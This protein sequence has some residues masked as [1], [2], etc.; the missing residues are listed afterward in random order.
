MKAMILRRQGP[1]EDRPLEHAD[2][3][4]SEP[5][6]GELV[7][8]VSACAVCHTDL[9]VVEG[10]LPPIVLPIVPGHQIVGVVEQAG[11]G[12]TQVKTG[13]RVGIPWLRRTCGACRYCLD[14]LENLCEGAEF[15]G[16]HAHGGYAEY[17]VAPAEFVYPL[18]ASFPDE[19][20]A[21]LLCAGVI[22]YRALRLCEV[23]P[24]G[25]L[26]LY[27]FG[28]SAH[29]VLQ[30]ARF[31]GCQVY[32]FTRSEEHRQHAR[33]LGAAW[34]GGANEQAVPE[35]DAGIIFAPAGWLVPLALGALRPAGTLALAGIHMSPIPELDYRLLYR[36]RTLRSV[37]NLTRQ[38]VR[39]FLDVA[40][41]IRI[42]TEVTAYRLEQAN[43]ALEAVKRGAVQ[44]AAVLRIRD[45]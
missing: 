41:Q 18:P 31:W 12:V 45:G 15:T 38:D 7:V 6:P 19:A 42:R 24:G 39:E 40:A 21:P 16:Y 1:I 28:A 29:L 8:R 32:V 33:E 26:G 25:R 27:G 36:E 3:P 20:A 10:D 43:D 9:H 2:L 30:V 17:A 5:G 13:D 44:G 11:A 23:R 22:G 4:E 14:G 35:I 34:A 37:A